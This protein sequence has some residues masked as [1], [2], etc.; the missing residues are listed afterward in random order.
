MS[1][2]PSALLESLHDHLTTQTALL[3]ALHAQLGLPPS[4]LA[5]ELSTLRTIL[6]EAVEAQIQARQKEVG[7]WV[8][9]C[10]E[11]ESDCTK[12]GKALGAHAKGLSTIGE[13]R[14]QTVIPRRHEQLLT[15]QDKLRQLY[16]GK[17]E[18]LTTLSNRL[19]ALTRTLGTGFFPPDI[20]RPTRPRVSLTLSTSGD[21][22]GDTAN[23]LDVTPERFNKIEKELIRGKAEVT[24]RT[25]NLTGLLRE[26]AFT[27]EELELPHPP[28]PSTDAAANIHLAVLTRYMDRFFADSGDGIIELEGLDPNCEI[29]QWAEKYK[30]EL[31]EEKERREN[32]IQDMYDQLEVLW[33]RLGVDADDID[34]FIEGN[35]GIANANILAYE[36]ELEKMLELKR[37]SMSEF[38]SNAREEIQALWE[39]LM[40][41][42]EERAEF[43]AFYDDEH[44]EELLVMH[45]EEI[46]KLKEERRTKLPILGSITKYFEIC[47]EEKDLAAAAQDQSRLTGRGPRDPGRLLREEKM[48]KRVKKD[49]P[50]LEQELLVAV[51]TWEAAN[52]RTFLISGCRMVDLLFESMEAGSTNKEN[53]KK[54]QAGSATPAT[55]ARST[56]PAAS[57]G[58][59]NPRKH[60]EPSSSVSQPSGPN[61]RPRLTTV[62][63]PSAYGSGRNPLGSSVFH[64]A[65]GYNI[66]PVPSLPASVAKSQ[67][68]PTSGLPRP[69]SHVPSYASPTKSK[70][71]YGSSNNGLGIGLPSM[72]RNVSASSYRTISGSSATSSSSRARTASNRSRRGSFKPRPSADGFAV[73]KRAGGPAVGVPAMFLSARVKEEEES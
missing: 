8:Y 72:Q 53:K 69:T 30:I 49:K 21:P 38:I 2:T 65:H 13:L 48:R 34:M 58:P 56:T 41:G 22:S 68:A 7:E 47:Q 28:P 27:Y 12:L 10:E 59:P 42:P 54:P 31:D 32:L 29:I 33:K 71:A 17:L 67:R 73:A 62:H 36:E 55:R 63:T 9:K 60:A 14:K 37:Q 43:S 51:P 16:Q 45:E 11:I 20:L 52:G 44:T 5:T 25:E 35:R 66:P 39:E 26:I 50:R 61:K 1:L 23:L 15:L 6:A 4:A 18:Q 57:T 64:N 19:T 46:M 70:M 24:Q 3:P 40:L